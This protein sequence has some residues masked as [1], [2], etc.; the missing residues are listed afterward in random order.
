M[1][2]AS[3]HPHIMFG[4]YH[5]LVRSYAETIL[6]DMRENKGNSKTKPK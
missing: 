2:I 4:T 1:D 6:L 5:E 3:R